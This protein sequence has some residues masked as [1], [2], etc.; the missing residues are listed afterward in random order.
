MSLHEHK[1]HRILLFWVLFLMLSGLLILASASL[2]KSQ[3]TF[4][5]NYYYLKHQ[6]IFGVLLGSACFLLALRTK[7]I[8]WQKIAI[9]IFFVSLALS[10]LLF[11]PQFGLKLG[12]ARQWIDLGSQTFQPSEFVKIGFVIYMSAWLSK[13]SRD[14]NSFGKTILP[15]VFLNLFIGI[16]FLAQKD[17]GG[18]LITY[19]C[20]GLLLFLSGLNYRR[21]FALIAMALVILIPLI[22]FSSYRLPR[23]MS[24][25]QPDLDPSGSSYQIRQSLIAI[26]SG[27]ILGKGYGQ[28]LQKTGYLPEVLGD[29]TFAVLVEELGLIG[30]SILVLSF[31][32]FSFL[33]LRIAKRAPDDFAKLCAAGITVMIT[34]QAFINIGAISGLIPLTG[35]TL[36]LVSYGSSSYTIT[37]F[38]LGILANISKYTKNKNI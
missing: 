18:L 28:S 11:L 29:S 4:G 25:L 22:L 24:F 32:F 16:L 21:L 6:F 5:E 33:G 12:G 30:G 36:P 34:W 20:S 27:G 31:L 15:F 7:Y 8:F 9:F 38:S 14:I 13:R 3:E 26:G 10:V 17:M 1:P 35:L 2:V 19:I 23:I 37:L